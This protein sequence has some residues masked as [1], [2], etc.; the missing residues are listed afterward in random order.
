MPFKYLKY[1]A[2]MTR[3]LSYCVLLCSRAR[4]AGAG[5]PGV[6]QQAHLSEHCVVTLAVSWKVEIQLFFFFFIR[7]MPV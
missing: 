2:C 3:G 4:G 7:Q 6:L 5:F 1:V